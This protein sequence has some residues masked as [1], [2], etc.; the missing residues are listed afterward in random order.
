PTLG[1]DVLIGSGSR[2][3][4]PIKVGD[5]AKIAAGAVVLA[6]V[7]PCPML[8]ICGRQDKAGFLLRF[9]R[10]WS[11]QQQLPLQWIDGAGHNANVDAP[12]VVNAAI[13]SFVINLMAD[14]P[15]Q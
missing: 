6:E 14:L 13:E 10:C 7:P 8:L 11:Q 2:V 1:N 12:L 15:S 9:N 4:G 3:L 5:H